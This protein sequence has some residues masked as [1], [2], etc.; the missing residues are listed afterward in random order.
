MLA[1]N[2]KPVSKLGSAPDSHPEPAGASSATAGVPLPDRPE[3]RR[4]R[5]LLQMWSEDLEEGQRC[6]RYVIIRD[7]DGQLHAVAATAVSVLRV[8]EDGTLLML[9]G[10]RALLVD[11]SMGKVLSWLDGRG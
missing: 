3:D 2:Y 1:R 4:K 10:G 11:Q 7:A 8:V 6:G 9:P 5:E